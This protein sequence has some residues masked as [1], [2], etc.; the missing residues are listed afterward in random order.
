MKMLLGLALVTTLA[1]CGVDGEPEQ[2]KVEG[3]VL[4]SSSPPHVVGTIGMRRGP[5]TLLLGV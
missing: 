5:I 3:E 4:L 1:A 2:P